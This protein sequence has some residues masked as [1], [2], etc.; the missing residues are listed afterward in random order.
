MNPYRIIALL[1]AFFNSPDFSVRGR[2][3][4]GALGAL[5]TD[6]S[7]NDF[8]PDEL[9]CA[10]SVNSIHRRVFGFEI[11]GELST[12]RMYKVLLNSPLFMGVDRPE[13]GDLIIS[14]TGYGNGKLPNGHVGICGKDGI[15]MSNDSATGK[16]VENYTQEEWRRRYAVKG[17]YPIKYFRKIN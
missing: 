15:I 17:G 9:G 4:L 8:A 13:A 2:F 1:K 6:A 16:F 7:P 10:E 11:G 14:P 5:G 3:Y 12:N